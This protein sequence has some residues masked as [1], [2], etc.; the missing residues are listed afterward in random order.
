MEAT[1]AKKGEAPRRK[2]QPIRVWCLPEE[3]AQIEA[4]ARDAGLSVSSYLRNVGMGYKIQGV[5]DAELVGRLAKINGD[6]GRL[7]GLLKLWL[8]NSEK[9]GPHDPDQMRR[10]IHG[11]LER[12]VT[13]QSAL[14]ELARK[15]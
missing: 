5:I 10:V 9:L 11:V 1:D 15:S 6:Q 4:N 7:G 8:T 12:I 13:M 14:L 2:L 3:K